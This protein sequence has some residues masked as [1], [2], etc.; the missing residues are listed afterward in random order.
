LAASI[1]TCRDSTKHFISSYSDLTGW[2]LHFMLCA[3]KPGMQ[4]DR[5]SRSTPANQHREPVLPRATKPPRRIPHLIITPGA[6]FA[7][8]TCARRR[9]NN[10][11]TTDTPMQSG[12]RFWNQFSGLR[13]R[14]RAALKMILARPHSLYPTPALIVPQRRPVSCTLLSSRFSFPCRSRC[15][16]CFFKFSLTRLR[17]RTPPT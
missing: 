1:L 14:S 4:D 10:W 6:N 17:S 13:T 7:I 5:F 15:L 2:R 9:E 16:P 8:G 12:L 11:V 3:I